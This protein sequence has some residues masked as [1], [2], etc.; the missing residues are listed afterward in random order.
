MVSFAS[1]QNDTYTWNVTVP[2]EP[3]PKSTISCNAFPIALSQ[4]SVSVSPPGSGSNEY[5]DPSEFDF[6]TTPP[7]YNSFISHVPGVTLTMAQEGYL[8]RLYDGFSTGDFGWLRWNEGRPDDDLRLRD[9]L[10]WPGNNKDYKDHGYTEIFPATPL[11][12]WIVN[13]YVDPSDDTDIELSIDD[14]VLAKSNTITSTVVQSVLNEHIANKRTL[15]LVVWD[16]SIE[17]NKTY[18]TARIGVFHIVGYDIEPTTGTSWL[19]VEFSHWNTTCGQGDIDLSQVSLAGKTSG[20]VN[21]P[22]TFIANALPVTAT[23]PVTYTWQATDLNQ[24]IH[25]NDFRDEA[26]FSW[27]QPGTKTITVTAQNKEGIFVQ[28]VH[29]IFV[30][31][32]YVYLP[33]IISQD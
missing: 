20:Y 12:S 13:G 3:I 17:A 11:F 14:P 6:P 10:A 29:S 7:D 31:L 28:D 8:Y 33:T 27:P 32:R 9:S 25:I 19:T 16:E 1:R 18:T 2:E 26:T 24:I 30:D 23:T 21:N 5:P 4:E 22:Y 15:Q